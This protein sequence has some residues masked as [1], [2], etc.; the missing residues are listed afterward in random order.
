MS[1]Q[2]DIFDIEAM[3]K[4]QSDEMR[5]AWE[6]VY[7]WAFLNEQKREEYESDLG[8]IKGAFYAIKKIVG[9]DALINILDITK[10]ELNG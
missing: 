7:T 2:D 6:R 5:D 3:M 1:I 10:G 4:T 9:R 8:K